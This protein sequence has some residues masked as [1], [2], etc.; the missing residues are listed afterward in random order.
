[1]GES[2]WLPFYNITAMRWVGWNSL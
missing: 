1:M 2:F